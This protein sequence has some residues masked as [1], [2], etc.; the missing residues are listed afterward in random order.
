MDPEAETAEARRR[1]RRG[2]GG[3][4]HAME[5]RVV[6]PFFGSADRAAGSSTATVII[7]DRS[8]GE[9]RG[10]G[11]NP[12][13]AGED[14]HR[15]TKKGDDSRGGG[16]QRSRTASRPSPHPSC[17]ACCRAPDTPAS[18]AA[19]AEGWQVAQ[20][21]LAGKEG[22]K[23]NAGPEPSRHK[24]RAAQRVQRSACP[25]LSPAPARFLLLAVCAHK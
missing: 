10:Y 5:L 24:R 25:K 6:N 2:Q 7:P 23:A 21:Q 20:T 18:P 15:A 4:A 16:I 14:R 19:Q 9:G 22:G 8:K 11:Q 13:Q 1:Y 3:T 12:Q 17:T